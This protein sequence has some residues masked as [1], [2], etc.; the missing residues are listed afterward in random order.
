[1]GSSSPLNDRVISTS[2]AGSIYLYGNRLIEKPQLV[3][4]TVAKNQ[5]RLMEY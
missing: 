2:L 1:L 5:N 3:L 4:R